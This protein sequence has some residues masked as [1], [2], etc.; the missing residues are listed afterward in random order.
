[1][2]IRDRVKAPVKL[3]L[4]RDDDFLITGKRHPFEYDYAVG[5]DDSGR[6]TALQV[7]MAANCGFSADLSGP[8]ADRAI[9]HTDNAYYLQDVEITSYRCKT[10]T[11]SHTAFRGFGGPQGVI[12]IEALLG[13]IARHLHLDPLDVRLHNLYSDEAIAGTALKRDTTHYGM[14]V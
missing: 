12:L 4:D 5:F 2:C 3:R 7:M 8:V 14:P 1:M 11:Q 9:F 6:L 10:H 13:D